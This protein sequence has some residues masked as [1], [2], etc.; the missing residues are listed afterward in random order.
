MFLEKITVSDD[1][2]VA[3]AT[4]VTHWPALQTLH[5]QNNAYGE[6]GL[7]ALA[8]ALTQL[9]QLRCPDV[10]R[11]TDI[12]VVIEKDVRDVLWNIRSLSK[13]VCAGLIS[14]L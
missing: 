6:V 10:R 12:A 1:G 5:T 9:S 14:R 11:G 13:R 2:A 7:R 3:L 4:S 8:G